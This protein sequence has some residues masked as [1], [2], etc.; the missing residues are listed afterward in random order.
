MEAKK[1]VAAI[2]KTIDQT[3]AQAAA[4]GLA[5]GGAVGSRW[6]PTTPGAQQ[7]FAASSQEQDVFKRCINVLKAGA[8]LD[9]QMESVENPDTEAYLETIETYTYAVSLVDEAC[10]VNLNPQV[11]EK[12]EEKKSFVVNRMR[13]LEV[14]LAK[15]QEH[16]APPGPGMTNAKEPE[17]VAE[18]EATAAKYDTYPGL[19]EAPPEDRRGLREKAAV[20]APPAGSD[21]ESVQQVGQ[22][23]G[24]PHEFIRAC[25][26][27]DMDS[28]QQLLASGADANAIAPNTT[29]SAL[30]AA[31]AKGHLNIV[32]LL[33]EHEVSVN[34]RNGDAATPL[35][36]AT[37][38]GHLDVVSLL[39]ES[40]PRP[41]PA[42]APTA[43]ELLYPPAWQ[44]RV[45]NLCTKFPVLGQAAVVAALHAH[46]GHAGMA[47]GTLREHPLVERDNDTSTALFL[48]IRNG[49]TEIARL[50]LKHG[51][52]PNKLNKN[53]DTPLV[54]AAAM[55]QRDVMSLLLTEGGADPNKNGKNGSLPLGTATA[56]GQLDIARMLL[57]GGADPNKLTPDEGASF[58]IFTVQFGQLDAT[59]LLLE[60]GA[61]PNIPAKDG[62]TPLSMAALKGLPDIARQLL[63]SAADPNTSDLQGLTPLHLA[64]QENHIEV[65]RLLLEK[66]A[67]K[68]KTAFRGDMKGMTSLD[69][70]QYW[71]RN[72]YPAHSAVV[73]LLRNPDTTLQPHPA[74]QAP[75]QQQPTV[76]PAMA[77]PVQ[78]EEAEPPKPKRSGS[79]GAG[80]VKSKKSNANTTADAPFAVPA[81]A[82]GLTL[83]DMPEG[84]S[85]FE[86]LKCKKANGL[87]NAGTK[88]KNPRTSV[89]PSTAVD[90]AL[91]PAPSAAT[92]VTLA[93]MPAGLSTLEQL[94]WK[95]E[96]GLVPP[97]TKKPR[98]KKTCG[99]C[100]SSHI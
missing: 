50:L 66:G 33:L 44:G 16:I 37:K 2:T 83:D 87:R 24:D 95:K 11:V 23:M 78:V 80:D 12:L 17:P 73:S 18:A 57:D 30:H 10:V 62:G 51:A 59:S 15:S 45:D 19:V 7:M 98:A 58:L 92:G 79:T 70:A 76:S 99:C 67:D 9:T 46:D 100:G 89:N 41:Q 61:D 31:V 6:P 43:A 5:E 14:R 54:V 25:T 85:H 86:Q 4:P 96:H 26:L 32:G 34:V 75:P 40:D 52:D 65:A 69:V 36:L 90:P 42:H 22:V 27:G 71:Q 74:I 55:K 60:K 28:V 38:G 77:H 91:A 13:D 20:G 21:G 81:T 3:I 88:P 93:D 39:L 82:S 64:A 72:G 35:H 63:D 1:W 48:A 56:T 53:G 84:L 29:T 97:T 47:I 94:K 68:E 8:A 49:H